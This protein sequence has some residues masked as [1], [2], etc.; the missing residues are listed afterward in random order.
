MSKTVPNLTGVPE[1]MLWT[2]YNRAVEAKRADGVFRDPESIRIHDAL[3]YDYAR[4]FG[5]PDAAHALRA[6]ESDKLLRTWMAAHPG[7]TVVSLGEGLETQALRVDDGIVRWLSIDLP[8][9]IAIRERF[10]D[11]TDRR[12]HL[13][14]SATDHTWMDGV[15]AEKRVFVVAQG[16]FMYLEEAEVAALIQEFTSRF[17]GSELF[18]DSIP[19]W[20][21]EQTMKGMN[22]TPDYE[23]PPMPWGI[24]TFEIEPF[25]R[26]CNGSLLSCTNM[27]YQLPRGWLRLF[28]G[29]MGAMPGLKNRVPT[30]THARFAS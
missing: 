7:G 2:L 28:M 30:M 19:R 11:E 12:R 27:P 1:T 14:M 6:L 24:N 22:R 26:E 16:L 20:F 21:S 8:E 25:L 15:D 29:V 18:F 4:S 17:P 23:L 13:S 9:A 10:I 5:D 3:D